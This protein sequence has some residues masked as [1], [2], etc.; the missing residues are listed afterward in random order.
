MNKFST[1]L[2]TSHYLLWLPTR[3]RHDVG[4]AAGAGPAGRGPRL[5][6]H[7][8]TRIAKIACAV[9]SCLPIGVSAAL[10]G[11]FDDSR[12]AGEAAATG[13]VLRALQLYDRAIRSGDLDPLSLANTLYNRGALFV[14]LDI[15]DAA[16]NDFERSLEL[17]PDFALGHSSLAVIHALAGQNAKA[18][19]EFGL[20]LRIN[21]EDASAL[22]D[23]GAIHYKLGR[24][25]EAIF[26]FTAALRLD[27]AYAAAYYNRAVAWEELGVFDRAADD[28]R[29]LLIIDPDDEQAREDLR[30]LGADP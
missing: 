24:L 27:P 28:Y 22:N 16:A 14:D 18:M 17:R 6:Y 23:R 9:L 20:A 21:P 7:W 4:D 26:D 13:D 12:A 8:P 10:A 11:G 15:L 3:F 25:D 19:T 5:R 30:R 1:V 29:A 2:Y